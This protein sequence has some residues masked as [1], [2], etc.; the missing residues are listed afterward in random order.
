M[1]FYFKMGKI[2]RGYKSSKRLII[3]LIVERFVLKGLK[4]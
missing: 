4:Y 3:R 2:L 1:L